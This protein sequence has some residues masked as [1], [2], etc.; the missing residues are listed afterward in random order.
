MHDFILARCVRPAPRSPI[1]AR[2]LPPANFHQ[3]QRVERGDPE[4]GLRR[5]DLYAVDVDVE[6]D[7]TRADAHL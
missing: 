5:A 2:E 3:G 6:E 7:R 1:L 4:G